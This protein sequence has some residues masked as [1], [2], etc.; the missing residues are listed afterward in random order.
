MQDINGPVMGLVTQP[1]RFPCLTLADPR[2]SGCGAM[3]VGRRHGTTEGQCCFQLAAPLPGPPTE[4][5]LPLRIQRSQD[6]PT[7]QAQVLE[8]LHL[9]LSPRRFVCLLP[10]AVTGVGGRNDRTDQGKGRQASESADGQESAG[11]DLKCAVQPHHGFRVLRD[12]RDTFA[13]RAD[14]RF[15]GFGLPSRVPQRIH[16]LGDEDRSEQGSCDAPGKSHGSFLPYGVDMYPSG[17]ERRSGQGRGCIAELAGYCLGLMTAASTAASVF[18]ADGDFLLPTEAARGPWNVD[19]LHGGAVAALLVGSLTAEDQVM[20]RVLVELHGPVP[21]APLTIECGPVAGGRRVKR[22]S[23]ALRAGGHQVATASVTR[24]RQTEVALPAGATDHPLT[25]DPATAPDLSRPNLHAAGVVGWPSFDSLAMATRWERSERPGTQKLWLRLLL[26]IVAGQVTSGVQ[27][28]VAAADY[29]TSGTSARLPFS[30]WSFM[31]ADLTVSLSR[32]PVGEWIGMETDGIVQRTGTGLSI[33]QIHDQGGRVGQSVQSLLVEPRSIRPAPSRSNSQLATEW[34]DGKRA[35]DSGS[36]PGEQ[37]GQTCRHGQAWTIPGLRGRGLMA[38]LPDQLIRHPC[39][40]GVSAPAP[41]GPGG[42][43]ANITVVV[44]NA[45]RGG[46]L[47]RRWCAVLVRQVL[48]KAP[49]TVPPQCTIE[50]AAHLMGQNGVGSLLVVSGDEVV[51][52]VTDRDIAVRGIGA[53]RAL[54]TRVGEVM[55][56][57]PI[58]IQGSA[59]VFEA[60]QVLKEERVRR[61]PVLEEGALA[62]IVSVDDLLVSCVLELAAIVSPIAREIL[63]PE[64]SPSPVTDE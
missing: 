1:T 49:V 16:P 62:G 6:Q 61:I 47:R 52:I 26:P 20:V 54:A 22:Q 45:V 25:F 28:A 31:N 29:G 5:R 57:H 59:E 36:P 9:L 46:W 24:I 12:E 10:E 21:F 8:E 32:P 58:T 34:P 27:R 13:H 30:Q 33:G 41:G 48:R 15:C 19:V 44:A 7:Q 11:T 39:F 60:V 17:G 63:Q 3:R 18:E 23:A 4:R 55:T 43:G 37:G 38:L 42:D 35:A 2:C 53:G 64:F 56:E 14:H 50:E 51:G 40:Q